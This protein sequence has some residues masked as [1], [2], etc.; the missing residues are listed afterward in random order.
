MRP[1]HVKL[2]ALLGAFTILSGIIDASFSVN[3]LKLFTGDNFMPRRYS[4]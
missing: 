4:G 2:G 3:F 1:N